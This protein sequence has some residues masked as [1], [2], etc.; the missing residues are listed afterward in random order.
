MGWDPSVVP[1]P[2]DPATFERSH[3]DWDEP[4]QPAHARLLE[5]Y[6][7]L[8]RLRRTHPE[9]TN[10]RFDRVRVEYAEH[11]EGERWLR[12]RR[13][14]AEILANFSSKPRTVP[15]GGGHIL[16]GFATDAMA[17]FTTEFA[18][19]ATPGSTAGATAG[20]TTEADGTLMPPHS[21]VVRAGR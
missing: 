19:G 13:G 17:E 3:L 2:Q 5:L 7:T 15:S 20:S 9:F 18:A 21:V 12:L 16:L 8:A 11:D 14:S 1:D 10:P 4:A 6:R